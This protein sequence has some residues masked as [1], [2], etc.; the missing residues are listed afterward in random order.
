M[1][2]FPRIFHLGSLAECIQ[3]LHRAGAGGEVVYMVG[4]GEVVRGVGGGVQMTEERIA[5]QGKRTGNGVF[6]LSGR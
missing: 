3:L 1:R 2:N 6:G 4:E 5:G